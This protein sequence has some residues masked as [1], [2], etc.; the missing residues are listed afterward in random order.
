MD[1]VFSAALWLY[2]RGQRARAETPHALRSLLFGAV[3]SVKTADDD[4][5]YFNML[6]VV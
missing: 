4:R 5:S 2:G 6:A 1:G 3:W